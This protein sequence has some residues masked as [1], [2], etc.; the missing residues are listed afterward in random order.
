[1]LDPELTVSVPPAVTAA[2]GMDAITQLI[3]SY[4][5]KKA[6]PIPQ[7]LAVQGLQMALPSI[8]EAVSTAT[9]GEPREMMA[10]AA[11]LSGMALGQ[12]GAGHGPWRGRGPGRSL[13]HPARR[14]LALM[15]PVALRVNRQVRLPELARLSRRRTPD[16]TLDSGRPEAADRLIRRIEAALRPGQGAS[17]A[18][19]G[20]ATAGQIPALVRSSRGASMSGNPRDLSDDELTAIL[21]EIL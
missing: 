20:G 11:L 1:M 16:G 12:F 17:A 9:G 8:A 4:L 6:Q 21:E 19:P 2:S 7:A 15:L 5:S 3:E 13:P 14:R 10:H 18:L